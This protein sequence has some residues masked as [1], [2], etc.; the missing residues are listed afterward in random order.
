MAGPDFSRPAA[1]ALPLRRLAAA[2][3]DCVVWLLEMGRPGTFPDT[4]ATILSDEERQRMGRFH[5]AEDRTRYLQSHYAL[6]RL[7]AEATGRQPQDLT[8]AE[9]PRGKPFLAEA[10]SPGFSLSHS[11]GW[12]TIAIAPGRQV[13][14]DIETPAAGLDAL[15]LA[16]TVLSPA[17]ANRLAQ[18]PAAEQTDRFLRLWTAKE[19][20]LKALGW[21]IADHLQD[22]TVDLGADRLG[23]QAVA[24]R[25]GPALSK[26]QA[27]PLSVP[28]PCRGAVAL[29]DESP[30]A[31]RPC[32][33]P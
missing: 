30:D 27:F 4:A 1:E 28:L 13:G 24:T 15:A 23:L 9:G 5:R 32:P 12:A 6:R 33:R 2:P 10:G 19:G 7:L 8:F 20:V 11:G 16:R 26:V 25:L 14:V 18:T 21:G 3:A 17:E 22:F 29:Y 31:A